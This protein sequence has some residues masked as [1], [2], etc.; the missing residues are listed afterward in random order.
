MHWGFEINL[1]LGSVLYFFSSRDSL[2]NKL[3]LGCRKTESY[4]KRTSF[5][6]NE[7]FASGHCY[8]QTTLSLMEVVDPEN[9]LETSLPS[10][11]ENVEEVQENPGN[12]VE[13]LLHTLLGNSNG[14]EMKLNGTV[15]GRS[16][17]I[18]I[19]SGSIDNQHIAPFGV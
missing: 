8:K 6:C 16:V 9:S 15:L 2:C 1:S 19:D 13:I 4:C 5:H 10:S 17:L 18:L 12:F 7:K 14:T 11:S 3:L